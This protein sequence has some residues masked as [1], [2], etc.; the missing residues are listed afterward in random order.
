[1]ELR[2]LGV[3]AAVFFALS[4]SALAAETPLALVPQAVAAPNP[5]GS[6]VSR[7]IEALCGQTVHAIANPTHAKLNA[8][9]VPRGQSVIDITYYQNASKVGG[10]ALAAY[11]EATIRFGVARNL[12]MFVDAPSD[13]AKS[14]LDGLG[15]FYF[16]HPG[17]GLKAQLMQTRVFAS[18][19]SVETRP[20]L[21]ALSHM[22]LVPLAE[23]ALTGSWAPPRSNLILTAQGGAFWFRQRGMGHAQRTSAT[24]ALA[25]T[26]P[27]AHKTWLTLQLRSIS[28]AAMNSAAQTSGTLSVQHEFGRNVLISAQ[29]GTAFN[30]AGHSKAHYL[31]FG[32][33]IRR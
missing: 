24:F 9:V 14:G 25:V 8:C 7:Q 5:A 26:A 31:G 11:P 27:V 4:G 22:S 30:A 16:T 1:M 15:V 19:F 20:Q 32:F 33:T 17:F 21:N 18:S 29:L 6:T 23:A 10:T 13:V 28:A 12:E 3:I 2:V